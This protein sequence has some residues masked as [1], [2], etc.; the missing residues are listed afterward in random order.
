MTPN[1]YRAQGVEIMREKAWQAMER[2]KVL[3]G[4][5]DWQYAAQ[6]CL[7]MIDGCNQVIKEILDDTLPEKFKNICI[8]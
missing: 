4:P 8:D 7:G 6:V 3:M 1:E 5:D 2:A